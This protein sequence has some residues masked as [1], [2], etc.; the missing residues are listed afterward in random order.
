M[1]DSES[2]VFSDDSLADI[3][4]GGDLG[5]DTYVDRQDEHVIASDTGAAKGGDDNEISIS[6][7]VEAD[8]KALFKNLKIFHANKIIEDA[9]EGVTL[10]K[11]GFGTV[12]TAKHED[13]SVAVKLVKFKDYKDFKNPAR[14]KLL[15]CLILKI[16]TKLLTC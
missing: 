9:D 1:S 14:Q 12:Y 4:Y 3:G 8:I 6:K 15:Y 5:N 16:V 10:G 13:Q 7:K 2:D 11:G